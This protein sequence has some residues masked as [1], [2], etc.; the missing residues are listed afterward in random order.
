[1]KILQLHSDFIEYQPIRKEIAGAEEADK[2]RARLEDLAVLFTAV[3]KGDDQQTAARAMDE[4]K[5]SLERI[6]ASRVLIYPYAHLSSNLAPPAEALT[7]LKAM[8]K[9]SAELGIETHRAPFGWNKSFTVSVKGHPLAEQSRSI[10]PGDQVQG[11]RPSRAV[12]SEKKLKSKWYILEPGGELIPVKDFDFAGHEG[13]KRFADYEMQKVRAAQQ[14]PPH[15]TLMKKLEISDYEPG[16]DLGNLRWLAKGRLMKSLLERYVTQKVLEYGAM[17]IETP[18]MYDMQ[19]PSLSSYLSKFPARQYIV[20][21][22]DKEYFLRFAACFG[23]FLVAHDMQISYKHL[24]VKIYELTR[25]SFRRELSGELVGL[26]RLRAFTMPDVHAFCRD[27]DQAKEEAIR[28]MKLSIEVLEG[29]G[30]GK[31]DYEIG[32]RLTEQFYEENKDFVN[33]LLSVVGKPALV[34]MWEERF[35]YFVEKWEFNFIDNLNKAS[36]LS[37]DQIDIENA[38]RY[39]ITYTDEEGK[40]RY[41]IILHCSPSGAIERDVYALLE[42]AYREQ[43]KGHKPMFPLWLA[44]VQIRI[45]PVSDRYVEEAARLM[46]SL[47]KENMR[48]DLDDRPESVEKKVRQAETEWVNYVIVFG[49]KEAESKVLSVRDR[50]SGK[51]RALS[52]HEIVEEIKKQTAGKPC[53]PLSLPRFLSQRPSFR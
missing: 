33:S 22:E 44:P 2:S 53:A 25:Y 9:R 3:E 51:I 11:E 36:A 4:I 42:K 8:E 23:Q 17:E 32:L 41:P 31:E 19:H 40:S 7:V 13:L 34:E 18:V 10:A 37:T 50:S 24:P 38:E 52:L 21:S 48:V 26:R 43:K 35:F 29:M 1:M 12:E 49:E 27:L 46:E 30:V 20:Q 14:I 16:S 15:V 39:S 6:G 47:E 5:E 28:R 45:V